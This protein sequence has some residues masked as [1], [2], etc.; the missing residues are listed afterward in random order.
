MKKMER[1]LKRKEIEY[2]LKYQEIEK[3]K[4]LNNSNK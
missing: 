3:N 1:K 4:K 2:L